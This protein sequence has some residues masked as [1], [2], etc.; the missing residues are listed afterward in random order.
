M[1]N[2]PAPSLIRV[3][4]IDDDEE[5]YL[6]TRE[7]LSEIETARFAVT[8]FA[9]PD[10]ALRELQDGALFDICLLDYRM[11]RRNGLDVLPEIVAACSAIPIILLT[12]QND[13]HVDREAVRRGA[14]DFLVKGEADA[15]LLERSIRYA[16]RQKRTEEELRQQ[17]TFVSAVLDTAGAL[18][19]VVDREGRIVRFNRACERLS[20]YS[21][22]ELEGEN[23][24]L[25]LPP[26]MKTS[27]MDTLARL[28]AGDFPYQRENDWLTRSGERRRIVFNN[29]CLTDRDGNVEYVVSSGIDVTDQRRAEAALA[30]ARER[31]LEVGASIQKTLLVRSAPT[32]IPGVTFGAFTRAAQRVGGDYLDFFVYDDRCVDVLVGDV[33]GKGV[34]AALLAAATKNHFQRAVRRLVHDLIPFGRLP[35]P[36]EIVEAVHRALTPELYRLCSFVTLSYTRF[37]LQRRQA[38]FVDCGHPAP[39]HFD[40]TGPFRKL[41]GENVPLGL[42]LEERYR[43]RT[44]PFGPDDLFF[45]YSDGLFETTDPEETPF[46]VERLI[47]SVER[48][49]H[50]APA[51]I[52]SSVCA[53]VE[54]FGVDGLIDDDRTCVVVKIARDPMPAS[55]MV[56]HK[57]VP[58][59]LEYLD[60]ARDFVEAALQEGTA[61]G[62]TQDEIF[63]L[64]L[65]SHE[66]I[67]NILRHAYPPDDADVAP[68]SD[69]PSETIRIEVQCFT[70]RVILDL[71]DTGV[72]FYPPER[73]PPPILDGTREGGFGL[74]LI[75]EAVDDMLYRRDDFGRNLLRLTKNYTHPSI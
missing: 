43:Q 26:E 67:T 29:T 49:R 40:A 10:V 71:R 57:E 54:A 59:R 3:L 39:L 45:F 68:D 1:E 24:D 25:L 38:T 18:V 30:E 51:E 74:F 63:R 15:I 72:A 48:L 42:C 75:R 33:M 37:D 27:V 64:V 7:L 11:G 22:A 21:F 28:V 55:R 16:M 20:G 66:A 17:R 4:L 58:A 41:G 44:V 32:H 14:S 47:A 36:Q 5:D 62:L 56:R 13:S 69:R 19:L 70:D 6:I 52:A 12:G 9:N 35:E 61:D 23:F 34:P 2:T 73:I 46:G 8:W 60:E 31:E 50:C 53:E 65:A